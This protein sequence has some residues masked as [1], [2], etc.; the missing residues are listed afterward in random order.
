MGL[1]GLKRPVGIKGVKGFEGV[2]DGFRRYWFL[3]LE[4]EAG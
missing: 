4:R 1:E 3:V 2:S